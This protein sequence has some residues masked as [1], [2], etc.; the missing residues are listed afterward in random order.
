MEIITNLLGETV[1]AGRFVLGYPDQKTERHIEAIG[2]VRALFLNRD[3]DPCA[4]VEV[5][6]KFTNAAGE[7]GDLRSFGLYNGAFI[8]PVKRCADCK[9]WAPS[10][11][12]RTYLD[13]SLNDVEAVHAAGYGCKATGLRK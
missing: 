2:I 6:E 10:H 8:R 3:N 5:I 4:V 11:E 13:P 12:V 9:R 1:E 7:I